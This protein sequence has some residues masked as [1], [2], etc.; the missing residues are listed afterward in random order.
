MPKDIKL[1]AS[2]LQNLI[3]SSS[4]DATLRSKLNDL[5][6]DLKNVAKDAEI[7]AQK[8]KAAGNSTGVS[9]AKVRPMGASVCPTCGQKLP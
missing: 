8:A 3:T 4:M 7:E 9:P 1:I 5:Y 6:N 2:L